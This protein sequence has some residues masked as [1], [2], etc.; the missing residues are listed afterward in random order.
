M[1]HLIPLLL[2]S[3]PFS[4]NADV[5]IASGFDFLHDKG[6]PYTEIRYHGEDWKYWTVYAGTDN[7]FGGDL[8]YTL[9][10]QWEVGFGIEHANGGEDSKVETE[11]AYQGRIDYNIDEHWAVSYKH[12]SNCKDLCRQFPGLSWMPK[13]SE[14][15]HN[16][17]LN[18]ITLR[19]TF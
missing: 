14:D 17:G 19:Y 2:L 1:K 5:S 10:K 4:A 11:A 12:R 16:S 3:L 6:K 7:T 18:Y 8:Y 9:F 15:K 13:G